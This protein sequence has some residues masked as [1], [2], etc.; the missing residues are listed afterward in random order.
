MTTPAADFGW[1]HD[2]LPPRRTWWPEHAHE[3]ERIGQTRLERIITDLHWEGP[4][5][6]P[7]APSV[8]TV[9]T[10]IYQLKLPLVTAA[11]F[12]RDLAPDLLVGLQVIFHE[13]RAH[14]YVLKRDDHVRLLVS[15]FWPYP[16]PIG[17]TI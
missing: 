12:N 11:A 17:I 8:A 2:P 4:P 15:D 5:A 1:F 3:I 6:D 13:G 7:S 16:G 14:L 10:L 9:Q